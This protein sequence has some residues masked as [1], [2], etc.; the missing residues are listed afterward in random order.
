MYTSLN[1]SHQDA[2]KIVRGIQAKLEEESK[3]AAIAVVDTHGEL[4][5]FLRT[6]G[7]PLPS[8]TIAMNKAFTAVRQGKPSAEVGRSS[9]EGN[10]PMT[11]FG[12]LRFTAWGGGVPIEVEGQIVGAVAVS[13]LAES[14]DIELAQGAATTFSQEIGNE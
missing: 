5:A 3:G 6:D 9:R 2:L 1:L 13:G 11:N 4:L 7:C 10:Y 12:D 14:E 8:I